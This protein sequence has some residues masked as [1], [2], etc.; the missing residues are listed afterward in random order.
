MFFSSLR[1]TLTRR[2]K[3]WRNSQKRDENRQEIIEEGRLAQKLVGA[4]I[5]QAYDRGV[6]DGEALATI[7]NDESGKQRVL[8][9][10]DQPDPEELLQ[11]YT[12]VFVARKCK[13]FK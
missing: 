3:K 9:F 8:D 4:T 2:R 7:R 1:V 13:N 6:E 12:P 11:I 10:L 5:E